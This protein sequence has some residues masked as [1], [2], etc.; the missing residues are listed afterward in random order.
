MDHQRCV[1]QHGV[2][3]CWL[4]DLQQMERLRQEKVIFFIWACLIQRGRKHR[5]SEGAYWHADKL[6]SS[7]YA[8]CG[9]LRGSGHMLLTFLLRSVKQLHCNS[10]LPMTTAL[11]WKCLVMWLSGDHTLHIQLLHCFT[12]L[13]YP[14]QALLEHLAIGLLITS[15]NVSL[16]Q[17]YRA[18]LC[19]FLQVGWGRWTM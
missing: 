16:V 13:Y 7:F 19:L 10:V 8:T 17:C 6:R 12:F 2:P 4:V 14:M 5:N 18:L 15:P 11:I 9:L 3:L 1:H